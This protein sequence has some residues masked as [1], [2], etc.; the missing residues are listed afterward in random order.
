LLSS[1]GLIAGRQSAI[2][3]TEGPWRSIASQKFRSSATLYPPLS[4]AQK[5]Q[6][7]NEWGVTVVHG[8]PDALQLDDE[9][10][11]VSV[12]PDTLNSLSQHTGLQSAEVMRFMGFLRRQLTALGNQIIFSSDYR[13]PR[14]KIIVEHFLRQLFQQGALRG[15]TADSAFRVTVDNSREGM[16]AFDIEVAPSFPI[17]RIHLKFTNEAGTWS[18]V[19]LHV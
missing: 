15:D 19:Q 6:C 7:R 1:V 14:P 11:A 17:D 12:L 8:R 2:S 3:Q 16:I 9:R 5:L 4:I 10:L 13:D 18:G